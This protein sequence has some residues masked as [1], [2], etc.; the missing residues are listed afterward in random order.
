MNGLC[1]ISIYV[2]DMDAAKKF[3]CEKLG[4][5][6]AEEYDAATV[7]LKHDGITI[8]LCK[9]E[10]PAASSYPDTA[11]V[12]LGFETENLLTK[13]NQLTDKGVAMIYDEPQPCP[14]GYFNAFLDPFGNAIELLEF[15]K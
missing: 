13:M 8:V 5:E 1:V 3:Y 9:T 15:H 4:F 7:G 12:V 11:Q 2:S 14:P 10:R 6:I